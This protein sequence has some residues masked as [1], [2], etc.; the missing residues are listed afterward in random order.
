M[1]LRAA[2]RITSR[3]WG[4][5]DCGVSRVFERNAILGMGATSGRVE[6]AIALSPPDINIPSGETITVKLINPVTF[7]P[8]ILER[9]MEPAVP[10]LDTFK[11]VPSLSFLLEHPSGRKLVWDLGIRKDYLNYAP[12]V[13]NY[14]PSTGYTLNVTK[15]VA[16]ILVEGG[17]SLD[18]VEAVIWSHWHWDHIG[19]PSTFPTTTDLVVGA[20]FKEAMLPGAPANPES[21]LL[22]SDYAHRT[23]REISF[24]GPHVL[25]IGSFPAFDYFGDGS[26]YLLDTP[27]HAVGHLCGLARTTKGPDTFVLLGG[28]VCHFAGILRPSKYLPVPESIFPHPCHP[29]GDMALCP[30]SAFDDLQ[31]SRGREPTDALFD[32]CF[33]GDIPLA[34]KTVG[35]LQEFDCREDIFVIIAH[36]MAVAEGVEHF[37]ASLN[38]WKEKGWGKGLKWSFF[39]EMRSY[40]E[41]KGLA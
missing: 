29:Q 15:N 11:E 16:D 25:R 19:D 26:F 41:S 28:D 8:S 37:P 6:D 33:G 27:G 14:I 30:G 21:P 4:E 36:D 12:Q 35:E 38:G 18:E 40:W 20:G 9:F 10:G 3:F 22:E 2:P 23:L 24:D 5:T 31:R 39:A 7:G 34:R 17:V 13:S 32:L 1:T